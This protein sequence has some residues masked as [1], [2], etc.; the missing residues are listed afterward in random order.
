[1]AGGGVAL[2]GPDPLVAPPVRPRLRSAAKELIVI[3][4]PRG[5]V[6]DAGT[7][8]PGEVCT[9]RQPSFCFD[10][11]DEALDQAFEAQMNH[12][13]RVIGFIGAVTSGAAFA[14][15]GACGDPRGRRPTSP[16]AERGPS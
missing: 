16:S 15:D 6:P 12:S 8:E 4:M 1:V 3:V 5:G 11:D 13:N 10:V 2:F 9:D 7:R 14:P